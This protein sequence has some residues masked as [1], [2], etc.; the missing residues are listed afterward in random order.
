MNRRRKFWSVA[1]INSYCSRSSMVT[2]V[3]TAPHVLW[4]DLDWQRYSEWAGL[5]LA[6]V[7][8]SPGGHMDS[9][10]SLGWDED[11]LI[12][13]PPYD[14]AVCKPLSSLPERM[15]MFWLYCQVYLGKT[16]CYLLLTSPVVKFE[17]PKQSQRNPCSSKIMIGNIIETSDTETGLGQKLFSYI[18]NSSLIILTCSSDLGHGF[19]MIVV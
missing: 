16:T 17:L 4:G 6:N 15:V 7:V 14:V 11:F 5:C 19:T 9:S 1:L 8:S 18:G 12:I 13:S 2:M 3:T 10:C